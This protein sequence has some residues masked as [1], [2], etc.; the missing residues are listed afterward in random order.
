MWNAAHRC[1]RTELTNAFVNVQWFSK[2]RFLRK[3]PLTKSTRS[4]VKYSI[5]STVLKSKPR[6]RFTVEII[7]YDIPVTPS[8]RLFSL[9]NACLSF[10]IISTENFAF[11]SLA[12]IRSLNF[13]QP[14]NAVQTAQVAKY[15]WGSAIDYNLIEKEKLWLKNKI[16]ALALRW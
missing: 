11:S 10:C 8:R 15:S 13:W 12:A 9:Y 4:T 7:R 1:L 16:V 5:P 2:Y 3:R 14:V 6:E